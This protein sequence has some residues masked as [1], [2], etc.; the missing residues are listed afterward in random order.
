[1]AE[2]YRSLDK[3][4]KD[5]MKTADNKTKE[6]SDKWAEIRDDATE[7]SYCWAVSQGTNEYKVL[8]SGTSVKEM[9]ESVTDENMHFGGVRVVINS[10]VQFFHVL[11]IGKGVSIVKRGKALLLKT[12]AFNAMP[13]ASGE[14]HLENGSEVS[15]NLIKDEI[16]KVAKC[17]PDNVQG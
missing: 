2:V 7:V 5:G 9:A 12:A 1:M 11:Y 17:Q 13:G 15:E 10:K 8:G 3:S 6:I 4:A 16:S 14:I